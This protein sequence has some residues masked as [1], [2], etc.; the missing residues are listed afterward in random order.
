MSNAPFLV[1]LAGWLAALAIPIILFYVLKVRLR[2]QPVSTTIFWR[3][4][5]EERRTRSLWRRLRHL[6]SLLVNLLFLLLLV[7]A[8]MNPVFLSQL[9]TAK[10]VIV[11]DNSLSMN[12][13]ED[14]T[15]KGSR[16][17]TAKSEIRRFISSMRQGHQVAILT[18]GGEPHVVVGFTD[19]LGTLRQKLG[20]VKPGAETTRI[21]DA[22]KLAREIS[23][24]DADTNI[25]VF[26]DGCSSD[27]EA[28]RKDE[29]VR[30]LPVGRFLENSAIVKF[31]PRRSP[32]DALGYEILVET[33]HYGKETVDCRLEVELDG[34]PVDVVPLTLEPNVPQTLIVQ[35]LTEKGGT[36]TGKLNVHDA[37][38]ADD[39]AF[40]PLPERK[41]QNILFYGDEDFFLGNVLQSQPNVALNVVK[42]LPAVLPADS[43]LVVHRTVPEALPQGNILLIDPRISG[44]LLRV[45]ENVEVP[46][47]GGQE[48]EQP[49]LRFVH[50]TNVLFPGAKIMKP[51]EIESEEYVFETLIETP[52]GD[53]LYTQITTPENKVLALSTELSRGELALRTAFPIMISNALTFFR[54][55]GGELQPATLL[56][57]PAESNL[58]SMPEDLDRWQN[59]NFR[60]EAANRPPWFLLALA[61]MFLSVTEW[62][63]F[64]RRWLD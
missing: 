61:A 46:I 32:G 3:R 39:T 31:Q 57:D 43:V 27:L 8:V 42:D 28:L 37:L 10:S 17:E 53:P 62:W 45:G 14:G 55:V 19:H 44:K 18:A 20:E 5:F 41:V 9:K 60:R 26:T 13:Q 1:P 29:D 58:A 35:G 64:Q 30:I 12:A 21:A 34:T 48:K 40:A 22:V 52:D 63:A 24:R 47:V 54:G 50:L 33:V 15:V 36:L 7:A 11:L 56:G 51:T 59:D 23:R 4:V 16:F 2:R 25:L 6:L 38:P 49:L